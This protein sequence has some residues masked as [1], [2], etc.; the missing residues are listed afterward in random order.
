MKNLVS[1]LLYPRTQDVQRIMDGKKGSVSLDL[2]LQ[3]TLVMQVSISSLVR[4]A[5]SLELQGYL[6]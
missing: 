2:P 6:E 1:P 5:A 3:L 4:I